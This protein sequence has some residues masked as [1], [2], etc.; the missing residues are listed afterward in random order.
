[1]GF[2][3]VL[4]QIL[5]LARQFL[6]LFKKGLQLISILVK[7]NGNQSYVMQYIPVLSCLFVSKYRNINYCLAI[8]KQ[9]DC[10]KY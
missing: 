6:L 3:N 9:I 1:M 2:L 10:I 4:S 5:Q 7:A 8:Q